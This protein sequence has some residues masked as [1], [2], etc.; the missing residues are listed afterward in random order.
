M[1]TKRLN[2][3]LWP[4][5]VPF[6]LV[7]CNKVDQLPA[8]HGV[9]IPP[10]ISEVFQFN[11]N[12]LVEGDKILETK[13]NS[14]FEVLGKT[15]NTMDGVLGNA[16]FF[17]GLTNQVSGKLSSDLAPKKDMIISTWVSPKTFPVG[18]AAILALTGEA[19]NSGVI[20]GINKFGQISL[21]YTINNE[22]SHFVTEEGL[23]KN[24]WN[25]VAIGL[26][27]TKKYGIV[28]LNG[29]PLLTVPVTS[30]SIT[31]PSSTLDVSIGKNVD[32]EKIGLYDIGFFSGAIDEIKLYKGEPTQQNI[33]DIK[34]EY[35]TLSAVD[36]SFKIDYTEDSNRPI[37]HPIPDYGWANESY[38]LLNHEGKY[39]MFYQKNDVFLGIAQ[40]NWG[41][42]TSSDLVLWNEEPT[43]LWPTVGWDNHGIWSGGALILEDGT[44]VVVY[45][46][47][48]GVKAGIGTA[49]SPDKYRTLIKNELNP[50]IGSAPYNVDMDFRD[51][52]VWHKDGQYHMLVGSGVSTIGAN[53][54]YYSSPDFTNW[55]YGGIA[56]QGN[57]EKGE[58]QFWEMPVLYS[59]PNGKEMLLVQKTPDQTPAITTYYIGEFENGVFKTDFEKAKNLEVVN[60]F[61][62][63]TVT[64]D[65]DGR[66]TA[67]GIIPDEVRPQFQKEQ[68]WANLFSVPQVWTLNAEQTIEIAPHPQLQNYR[69][70]STQFNNVVLEEGKT[71]YLQN[72]NGRHFEMD[73]TIQLGNRGQVGII[74]GK[75]PNNEEFYSIYYDMNNQEWVVDASKASLNN[76]ARNDIRKGSYTIN[77][78][79]TIHLRVF[80]DGSV[81]EVFVDDKV[82]FTGRFYP[83]LPASTGVDMFI[84][85]ST[86]TANINLYE[87]T[88]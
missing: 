59:F 63:P 60:G 16:L 88:N 78:G 64:T 37:Y 54:V 51:P 72:Y 19:Q 29:N 9:V 5:L 3:M 23:T 80:V 76:Q 8:D 11:F 44:P 47:V 32:G 82:H 15:V 4:M 22:V 21:K 10:N 75:S 41:H 27:T 14:S 68:G 86:A 50:I 48:D 58:G 13:T 69:G 84:T 62:S 38:G 49:T 67:I 65:T 40:Q 70:T 31:W 79:N 33:V 56:Y 46:G 35:T 43:V 52:Y 24:Q 66:I 6:M 28:Y 39:H 7:A 17:D 74:L 25:H 61:L 20:L 26:S 57:K 73:A 53:V 85:G 87:I 42:F 77:P 71:N 45:T 81:V 30:G 83:T 34:N 55:S 18:T 36:Y 12:A 2:S 1:D